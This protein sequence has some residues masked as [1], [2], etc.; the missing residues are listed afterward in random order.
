MTVEEVKM[1]FYM[2]FRKIPSAEFTFMQ[3]VVVKERSNEY[4]RDIYSRTGK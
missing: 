1:P 2:T 4:L 3:G